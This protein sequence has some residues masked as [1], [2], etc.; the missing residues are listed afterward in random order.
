MYCIAHEVFQSFFAK[1]FILILYHFVTSS[2]LINTGSLINI[3]STRLGNLILYSSQSIYPSIHMDRCLLLPSKIRSEMTELLESM[4]YLQAR[5][6]SSPINGEVLIR[7][8]CHSK[9]TSVREFRQYMCIGQCTKGR[10]TIIV[11]MIRPTVNY[12]DCELKKVRIKFERIIGGAV[13]GPSIMIGCNGR[14]QWVGN[15]S[16]FSSTMMQLF[17]HMSN[18]MSSS[19]FITA[20]SLSKVGTLQMYPKGVPRVS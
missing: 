18:K 7:P 15:P 17:S 3:L 16:L 1:N 20:V 14:F 8:V 5:A 9:D 11:W 10:R 2:H 12:L 4:G 6:V 19:Q 13:V